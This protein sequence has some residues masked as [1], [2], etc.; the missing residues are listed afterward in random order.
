[1]EAT[2]PMCAN[3][4]WVPHSQIVTNSRERVPRDIHTTRLGWVDNWG[5]GRGAGVGERNPILLGV[6]SQLLV[7]GCPLPQNQ[8]SA[9]HSYG[10]MPL[11][12]D[13]DNDYNQSCFS[14]AGAT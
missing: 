12:L 13:D 1:M 8:S 14:V 7:G 11:G 10:G 2:N 9:D 6:N 5:V 3:P 4:M